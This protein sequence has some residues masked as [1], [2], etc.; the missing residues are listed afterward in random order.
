[1]FLND[2]VVCNRYG[3]VDERSEYRLVGIRKTKLILEHA[4]MFEI[5]NGTK[6]NSYRPHVRKYIGG[7]RIYSLAKGCLVVVLECGNHG[8]KVPNGRFVHR[9]ELVE[10]GYPVLQQNKLLK[11]R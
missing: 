11:G 2:C 6:Q 1:M 10:D 5:S 7:P 3:V 4:V 8:T 9:R